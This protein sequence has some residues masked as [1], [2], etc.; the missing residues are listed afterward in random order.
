MSTYPPPPP[1]PPP[2]RRGGGHRRP[3]PR[4]LSFPRILKFQNIYILPAHPP[5]GIA[6]RNIRS[7][8]AGFPNF[9]CSMSSFWA[10]TCRAANTRPLEALLYSTRA[11]CGV[12][13]TRPASAAAA[14]TKP[15]RLIFL[16]CAVQA[17]CDVLLRA[18]C[19]V[20]RQ[21]S[22]EWHHAAPLAPHLRTGSRQLVATV[23]VV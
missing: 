6:C 9:C 23:R 14:K 18:D 13:V 1:S 12:T 22:R 20:L 21:R 15:N 3:T 10:D 17:A 19:C 16:C 4:H 2:R 7:K 5:Q 8:R 11:S